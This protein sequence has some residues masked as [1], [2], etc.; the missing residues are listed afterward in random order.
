MIF[1]FAI[2]CRSLRL[3]PEEAALYSIPAAATTTKEARQHD[4]GKRQADDHGCKTPS[5]I[6]DP[7]YVL[8]QHV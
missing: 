6:A 1:S 3:G 4:E 7:L 8:E 5:Q 2:E